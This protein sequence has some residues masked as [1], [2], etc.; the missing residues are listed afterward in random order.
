MNVGGSQQQ[1]GEHD[2][3]SISLLSPYY[4]FLTCTCSCTAPGRPYFSDSARSVMPSYGLFLNYSEVL[5]YVILMVVSKLRDAH[6]AAADSCPHAF[7][8]YNFV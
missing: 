5:P 2:T 4:K 6:P 1:Q 8:F 3:V 7:S